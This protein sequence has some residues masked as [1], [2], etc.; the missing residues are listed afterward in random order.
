MTTVAEIQ[1]EGEHNPEHSP[2]VLAAMAACVPLPTIELVEDVKSY[3]PQRDLLNVRNV[4]VSII[5]YFGNRGVP[6]DAKEAAVLLASLKDIDASALG[7]MR[8]KVDEKQAELGEQQRL[9]AIAVLRHMTQLKNDGQI[10]DVAP[11]EPRETPV[12]PDDV[13]TR[14]FVPGESEQGTVN[15]TFEQFQVRTGLKVELAKEDVDE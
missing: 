15:Q 1:T 11:V 5:N 13:L 9:A 7:Q 3:D 12:L 2:Q 10:I 14:D 6:K 4:R 8:I